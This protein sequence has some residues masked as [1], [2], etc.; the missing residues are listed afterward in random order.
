[1]CSGEANQQGRAEAHSFAS[2]PSVGRTDFRAAFCHHSFLPPPLQSFA[3]FFL[4][5]TD[6]HKS[7]Q[8]S[9]R[10]S[11]EADPCLLSRLRIETFGPIGAKRRN[12]QN[13]PQG[14]QKAVYEGRPVEGRR[15][16]KEPS[17]RRTMVEETPL[18]QEHSPFSDWD[19]EW[20]GSVRRWQ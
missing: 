8:S 16:G 2:G 7:H 20:C 13:G 11:K 1:M 14:C 10:E 5:R 15:H 6:L 19:S 18:T 4:C 9:Q 17:D 3:C 12:A